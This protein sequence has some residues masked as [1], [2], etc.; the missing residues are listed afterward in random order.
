MK[1][2]FLSFMVE[3]RQTVNGIRLLAS[4][5]RHPI[6][7]Y[8]ESVTTPYNSNNANYIK[9]Q[10]REKINRTTV[11]VCIISRNTHT[12]QWVNW[13]L[14]TSINKGNTIIPMGIPGLTNANL[15]PSINGQTWWLWDMAHLTRL[16]EEAQ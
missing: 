11:T 13:E 5:P 3:D 8:D 9:Q 12:S 4:N 7:F 16:I 2:V 10:I 1:R 6:E 15:P 14:E